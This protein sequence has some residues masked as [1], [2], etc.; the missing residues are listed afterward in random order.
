MATN[1]NHKPP[2]RIRAVIIDDNSEDHELIIRSAEKNIP[3]IQFDMRPKC[4]GTNPQTNNELI[5]GFLRPPSSLSSDEYSQLVKYLYANQPHLVFVDINGAPS[6]SSPNIN[7]ILAL[8]AL[9][10]A[11]GQVTS[12]HNIGD[13]SNT[14][15]QFDDWHENRPMVV[16]CSNHLNPR[17]SNPEDGRVYQEFMSKSNGDSISSLGKSSL[18][19]SS[20]ADE[21]FW[22]K[23]WVEL[24]NIYCPTVL[25]KSKKVRV[26][27][28]SLTNALI[29]FSGSDFMVVF[30]VD[31]ARIEI[32]TVP[33]RTFS[34]FGQLLEGIPV[35][36]VFDTSH[37]QHW[38]NL[39][40][41]A[42]IE[43]SQT[44]G[45]I[46]TWKSIYSEY[47]NDVKA[48]G[49]SQNNIQKVFLDAENVI[50]KWHLDKI[51][52]S[53]FGKPAEIWRSAHKKLNIN[54]L[55]NR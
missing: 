18:R 29:K 34:G 52:C 20:K 9:D 12:K 42:G 39:L 37:R 22:E 3:G 25:L 55:N 46:I 13:T 49:I 40:Q 33:L 35:I 54:L 24:S 26:N 16:C 17:S 41:V 47:K 36:S 2:Q 14:P 1:V 8:R 6:G 45:Y 43:A 31:A 21:V 27:T 10:Q 23:K 7:G 28:S 30:F 5:G 32:G 15:S 38:V 53:S 51:D 50:K 44:E 11:Y 19:D 48:I 4:I